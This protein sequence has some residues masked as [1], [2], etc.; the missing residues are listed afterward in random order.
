VFRLGPQILLEHDLAL[1]CF[2]QRDINALFKS[3]WNTRSREAHRRHNDEDDMSKRIAKRMWTYSDEFIP[4]PYSTIQ[5]P[6][7]VRSR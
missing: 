5:I 7:S 1:R 2:G 6:R 3:K 4:S